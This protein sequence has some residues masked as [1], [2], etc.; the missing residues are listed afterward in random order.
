MLSPK[1]EEKLRILEQK[2]TPMGQSLE[3]Y[4]D[5]LIY[6]DFIS[7]WDY[8]NLDALLNLQQPRTNFP[9]ENIFITYHQITELYFKLI[10]QELT[11]IP[12]NASNGAFMLEKIRRTNRYFSHLITSF[13]I[14]VEGMDREQFLQFRMA[15]LPASGFQS[16][17]IRMIELVSTHFVNLTKDPETQT[18]AP[19]IAEMYPFIYWKRGASELTTGK[20]TLTLLKFEHKYDKILLELAQSYEHTNICAVFEALPET[21]KTPELVAELRQ[22]DLNVNVRWKLMHL[23]S[24]MRYLQQPKQVVAATG[25]TNWQQYLPPKNQ[26]R[27]FFAPIWSSQEL[28]DWGKSM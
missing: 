9:D 21:E 7:Y 3:A 22:Y 19:T 28:A 25:G 10:L 15:L 27:T 18:S 16:A 4:L 24:A 20:K 8:I 12:Q 2:Y 26:L 6:S 13:D 5:G 14:M 17:Q 11:Q 23:K 1:I